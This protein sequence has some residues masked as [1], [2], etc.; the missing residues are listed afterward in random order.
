MGFLWALLAL[1]LLVLHVVPG[2]VGPAHAQ[3]S[4][5]DDI[6][7]NSRGV[8][9]AGATIRVCAM[10]ASGQPCTP[11]ALIYSDAALTQALAN[12]TSTDGL[13]NYFFYA[14]PGKYEIEIS[15]PAIA[16]KQIPNV[17][18]PND[19]ASPSFSGAVS[20]FSLTLSGNLTVN[21]NTTVLGNL[22][23]GTL[24]LTNQST[25][26]GSAS[27]GTVNLYT[28]TAD[29]RVYYKDE[30]GTE[31]GP[32]GP[33]NGAQTN[34][35]NT[36]TA[37][38]NF[39]NGM[40]IKG[41]DPYA[42]ITRF[43][44]FGT[45]SSTT[46]NTTSGSGSVALTSVQSFQNGEY[47][48]V[49]NAGAAN[50]ISAMG[51]VTLTPAL[52]AGG[53]NTVA[54]A[55]G[56]TSF[57]YKVVAAD[58]FGG[59]TAAST[60]ASTS[61]GNAL[62]VQTINI[63][64]MSRSG[65]TVTVLTAAPHPFVAGSMVY[66]T[67]I[68]GGGTNTDG[69]FNGFFIVKTAADS[70]HFTFDQG[71]DTAGGATTSDTGGIAVGFT[72]NHLT[73]SAVTGAWKYYIYG[74]V[75]GTWNLLGVTLDTFFDDFGSPMNDNKTFP[76]FIPTTAPSVG[77]NDHLTAQISSGG[78]TTTLTLASNA[79]A[80]LTGAGIVS[81]DGPALVAACAQFGAP[82][83][84]PSAGARVSSYT[85]IPGNAKM[86]MAGNVTTDD[87]IQLNG[88][89][90]I[91]GWLA[92]S[93]ASFAW[94]GNAGGFGGAK[95]Y[96]QITLNNGPFVFRKVAFNCTASNGC[97][98]L[99]D[100][101][102]GSPVSN[103]TMDSSVMSTGGGNTTD[104]LGMH[105]IFQADGFS[106][107]FD[108]MTFLTGSPGPNNTNSIGQSPIPTIVFKNKAGAAGLPTGNFAVTRSWFIAR[109][110][111]DQDYVTNS[112]GVNWVLMK[113]IQMQN[114]FLPAFMITGSG[115]IGGG[116]D[117]E[118][119][120][121]AD[122]PTAIIANLRS[123]SNTDFGLF[124]KNASSTTTTGN[125]FAGTFIN[126]GLVNQNTGYSQGG[127]FSN[128]NVAV[129]NGGSV[130][131]L[132][133]FPAAA[134]AVVSAG[135]SVPVGSVAYKITAVDANGNESNLSPAVTV[136]TTSGNQTVT[137][138]PP[139]LPAGAVGWRPYR[140][141]GGSY[142][143]A[144]IPVSCSS[145][146]ASGVTFVD[147]LSFTCGTSVPLSFP[148]TSS[149]L[150]TSGL[151]TTAVN[152]VGGGFKNTL[153]GA[154]TANRTQTLPDNS[155]VVPV[156]SYLNSAY[157]NAARANGAIG[158]NWT[159]QQNGLNIAS[160][161]IQGSAAG[162]SN[163]GFWNV[164]SFPANQFAQATITAL[165]G[166]TDFPGVSVLASGT[167]ASSTY[168]DCVENTTNIYI[169]RVV[170][171]GSTNIT[172]AASAGA[173][174]D[175]LRLEAAPGGALTCYKNGA[176]ALTVTDTQITS[177]SPGL[178]ISGNVA[179]EKNWS[180]G[181]LHPLGQLDIEQDWTKSQHFTQGIAFGTESFAASPRAVQNVFLPGALTTTW[182]GAT[183]TTDKAV[184]I[185]RIQVQA[186]TAP[187]GCTTNA[188]VRLTDGTTPVNLT[189]SAA[190]N[191]SGAISQNYPSASSLQVLVQTAAAGCTTSPA[192]ANVVVQY[193]MQ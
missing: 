64:S 125:L 157:D 81:D 43:G 183:W 67:Y 140:S 133:A 9:L 101:G 132:M 100:Y 29:K 49:Y 181:N 185:T 30:T 82:C 112:G 65:R 86:I 26:P 121:P 142:A 6:V 8:P 127:F 53:L 107:R 55:A 37:N 174:G 4:R 44:K 131:Y 161:Q 124:M 1:V 138:T 93:S 171:A 63:T 167:G 103:V 164:N 58:K 109:S 57:S 12:P 134:G 60:A 5:K 96:P 47:V 188:I 165:N 41:P 95:A 97:L 163:S 72:C 190:A 56:A 91:E 193:R 48:T 39:D 24:N 87:T 104:F 105:A 25:P 46:A 170:N 51:T 116:Y 102:S 15:G 13:G 153:S 38:Q 19:P 187:A 191:D 178:F 173:A 61:A 176:V 50:S 89:N 169:Q 33:G 76:S 152:V 98:S 74:R 35:A 18:L 2:A 146:V 115:S 118:D 52:N 73:W 114:A 128:L 94:E 186:K 99:T 182:T 141:T 84:V 75:S 71:F 54:A 70:T 160:N 27:A 34:V 144:G 88:G 177:G 155:G 17:I 151:A 180:G 184:T 59:Y 42:D 119:L 143:L 36:F 154:F 158:S 31:V 40:H 10:P 126:A 16:T 129:N 130:G 137:V 22:A 166:T 110:S 120:A 7:F 69:T 135:G 83:Y 175:L 21:G 162:Q 66:I 85:I 78:G 111:F 20:A 136:T 192:D 145:F 80:T 108:K 45:F 92:A 106:F 28:K 148:A 149:S 79:G 159:I 68:N 32:L 3:G 156:T 179:T 172:S 168:Y 150:T 113:D 139:V 189:I 11:L 117:F 123:P 77:A 122:F 62:G 147:T 90:V 23:S 14:A